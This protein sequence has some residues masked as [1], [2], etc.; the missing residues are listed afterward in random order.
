MCMIGG[1]HFAAMIVSL[2]PKVVRKQGVE[3]RQASVLAH[4]TFHRYTTR[5]KQGGAQSAND[6]AKG[7]AHSAGSSLRRYN[8]QALVDDVRSLLGEWKAMV[9]AC[10]LNFIRAT[11]STN[12][13][14][15]FGPYDGQVLRHNDPR[16]RGF[17]FST[18]RATQNELMRCFVEL[19]RAKTG[20]IT[21]ITQSA[22]RAE[23]ENTAAEAKNQQRQQAQQQQ[24]EPPKPT[25]TPE[26]AT[27][28]LHTTQLTALIKRSKVPALLSYLKTN[29]IHLPNFRFFSTP[30]DTKTHH[31]TPTPLHLAAS[32]NNPALI[33]ALLVRGGADPTTPN[34]DSRTPYELT[35]DRATRDA[36]RIA[37]FDLGEDARDWANSNIPAGMSKAESEKRIA[38]EK[39][40]ETEREGRRRE[41]GL[42]QL[43]EEEAKRERERE[44]RGDERFERKMGRG[45]SLMS[46][47]QPR[48]AEE[49]RK[50][51]S[52][53]LSEEMI[54]RLES[55]RRARAAEERMARLGGGGGGGGG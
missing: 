14:T 3:E 8:E 29:A 46:S 4:K 32:N 9:D 35:R 27:A 43:R 49:R 5:R 1:G 16:N 21:E 13:R 12:R 22:A 54:K 50:E 11:G 33:T 45:K 47:A 17:P 25:L 2:T 38:Q 26:Q 24:K 44:Q 18:R 55:E 48:T 28:Q 37:R 51:E 42:Q 19:T 36:F 41:E 34:G 20:S 23:A 52:R 6:S 31:H 30:E 40:E 10:E 15:L 53:G 39:A 7:A